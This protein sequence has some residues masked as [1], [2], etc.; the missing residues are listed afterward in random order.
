MA[1]EKLLDLQL[2]TQGINEVAVKVKEIYSSKAA[3]VTSL[4]D[5]TGTGKDGTFKYVMANSTQEVPVEYEITPSGVVTTPTWDA[6]NLQLTLP[7]TGGQSV[8]IDFAKDKFI[9]PTAN[10]RYEDGYLYLYLND[11]TGSTDPTEIAIPVTDLI[12][13]Y[14]GDDTDSI[15]VSVDNSTHK[16]TADANVRPDSAVAGSEFTNALKISS[17]ADAKGLYVDPAVIKSFFSG[18]N[19]TTVS[20][21]VTDGVV[22]SAA[23][24]KPDS[25]EVGSEFT[26]LLKSDASGLYVD[27][28]DITLTGVDNNGIGVSIANGTVEATAHVSDKADNLLSIVAADAGAGTSKGFYVSEAD[29]KGLLSFGDTNSVDGTYD[30]AT[31]AFTAD[32][33]VSNIAGNVLQTVAA[34]GATTAGMAV[35]LSYATQAEVVSAVDAA[36]ANA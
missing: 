10:N 34:E 27:A 1:N 23:I 26:N 7:V 24:I 22:Q 2:F 4:A 28:G 31:G 20:T 36:F 17:A 11:G 14:F 19:S 16:V 29:V 8:V 6:S 9:D 13:D 12:T 3:T 5:V 21:T 32:V 25:A 30:S 15:S 18:N 35:V 33:K